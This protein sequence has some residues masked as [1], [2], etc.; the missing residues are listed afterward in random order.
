MSATPSWRIW[1]A[2]SPNDFFNRLL[3]SMPT[4]KFFWKAH[5]WTGIVVATVVV[6]TSVTGFM[7]LLKKRVDWIQPPTLPGAAGGTEDFITVQTLLDVVFA[8]NNPDFRVP[9][10]IDRI[11]LRPDRR[12]FKVI[13]K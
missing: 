6:T 8:H 13:S 3:S 5:K 10:D 12:V 1:A 2:R 11:D 4:F 9:G 7:L